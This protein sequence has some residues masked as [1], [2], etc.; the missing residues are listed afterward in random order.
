[1]YLLFNKIKPNEENLTSFSLNQVNLP[2]VW[3]WL[4]TNIFSI[5]VAVIVIKIA[6]ST[7]SFMLHTNIVG[8]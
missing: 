2:D 3:K 8:G 7:A 4:H 1:M 5:R 6:V